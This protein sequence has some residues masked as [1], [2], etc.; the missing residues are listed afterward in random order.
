MAP[1]NEKEVNAHYLC[2]FAVVRSDRKTTKVRVVFDG[3]AKSIPASFSLNDR[4]EVGENHMPLLFDTLV[5]F[6]SQPIALTADIEAAFL[7][8][9]ISEDDRDV[10]R[11][12]WF[13]DVNKENPT[14]VEYRYC[15]LV[16]GLTCSP[17]ILGETIRKYIVQLQSEHPE[18]VEILSR[19]YA[20]DLF[21]GSSTVE[22]ALSLVHTCEADAEADA[23]AEAS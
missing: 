14:I 10:L 3:S 22:E 20:D 2:H 6:H 8:I 4:L 23:E 13:D 5:R 9:A 17:S 16:F 18:V 11:F 19:L 1:G 12:L 15:R 21:C 7:Q